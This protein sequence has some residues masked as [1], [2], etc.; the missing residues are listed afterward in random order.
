MLYWL[1]ENIGLISKHCWPSSMYLMARHQLTPKKWSPHQSAGD[2]LWF[3]LR[4]CVPK[5]PKFRRDTFEQRALAVSG[6]LAEE[7]MLSD[8]VWVIFSSNASKDPRFWS[9]LNNYCESP[10]HVIHTVCGSCQRKPNYWASDAFSFLQVATVPRQHC[11]V[12][13]LWL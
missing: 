4:D 5:D 13:L 10:W 3:T 11:K 12:K 6:P 8:G 7:M 9:N 1:P 2:I